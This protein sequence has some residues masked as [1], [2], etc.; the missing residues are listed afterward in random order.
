[1]AEEG[2]NETGTLERGLDERGT[3]LFLPFSC[4]FGTVPLLFY[5]RLLCDE[6]IVFASVFAV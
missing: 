6:G 2:D 1:M 5:S 4:L 3:A